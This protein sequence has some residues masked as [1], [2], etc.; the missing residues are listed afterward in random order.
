MNNINTILAIDTSCD[1]TA[2]AVT[3]QQKI[4]SNSVSS[5]IEIHRKYGGVYPTEAKRAHQQK[6]TPVIQ[7]ALQKALITIKKNNFLDSKTSKTLKT[8]EKIW[9]LVDAI[10]VTQGPGLAPA[11]QVGLNKAHQLAQ[12]HRKPLIAVNHLEGICFLRFYKIQKAILL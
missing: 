1:E 7:N 4:I 6:I 3:H 5:Q 9:Q 2:V 11:L 8:R 12:Q 10:A